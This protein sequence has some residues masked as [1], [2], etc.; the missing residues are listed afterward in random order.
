M[1]SNHA[2]SSAEIIESAQLRMER[3]LSQGKGKGRNIICHH[4]PAVREI[5]EA[6]E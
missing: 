3:A 1:V 6:A 4:A 2:H 5:L